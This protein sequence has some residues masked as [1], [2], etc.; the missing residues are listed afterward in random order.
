MHT[1]NMSDILSKAKEAL[2]EG[3]GA[4]ASGDYMEAIMAFRAGLRIL[5]NDY[6]GDANKTL[7]STPMRIQLAKWQEHGGQLRP[8]AYLLQDA[9]ETRIYLME[10]RR[11]E[12]SSLPLS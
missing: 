3:V 10:C 6:L 8:A 4:L 9:L 12:L 11:S 1:L 5:G 2:T 7:D